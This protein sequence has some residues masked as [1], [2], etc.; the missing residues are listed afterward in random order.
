MFKKTILA[1]LTLSAT[2]NTLVSASVDPS[3]VNKFTDIPHFINNVNLFIDMYDLDIF[4]DKSC[5]ADCLQKLVDADA[6]LEA[7]KVQIETYCI[8]T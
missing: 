3:M 8:R 5:D 2:K 6:D 4:Q 7:L 1:L